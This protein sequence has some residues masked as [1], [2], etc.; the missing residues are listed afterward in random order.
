MVPQVMLFQKIVSN[1][2]ALFSM[3]TPLGSRTE[4][5]KIPI[6]SRVVYIWNG[7]LNVVEVDAINIFKNP[8]DKYWTN[9]EVFYDSN[10]D[11]TR[12][13]GLPICI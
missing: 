5:K 6:C 3:Q 2:G 8:V 4:L 7:L 11:L 9:Q 1:L 13:A 12:T 10:A